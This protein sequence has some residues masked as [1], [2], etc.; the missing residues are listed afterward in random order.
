MFMILEASELFTHIF[1]NIFKHNLEIIWVVQR[2]TIDTCILACYPAAVLNPFDFF[3]I[4]S[5]AIMLS[6][7]ND[8]F[9]SSFLV[10]IPFISFSCIFVL[11]KTSSTVLNRN[12]E[13]G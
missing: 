8:I 9:I 12:G 13:R 2:N 6:V 3:W 5:N 10:F 4:F 11:S 1:F 7:T